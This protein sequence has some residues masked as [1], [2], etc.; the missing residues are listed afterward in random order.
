MCSTRAIKGVPIFPAR[1]V[2]KPAFLK[3]CSINEVVVVLPF[4]PVMPIKRPCR[5]RSASSTSLQIVM[6]LGRVACSKV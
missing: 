6:P 5:K 3:M 2:E 4:E 1:I